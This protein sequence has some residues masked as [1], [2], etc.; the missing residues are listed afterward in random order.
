MSATDAA[1]GAAVEALTDSTAS[2][3]VLTYCLSLFS[4]AAIGE[5][6]SEAANIN[7]AMH[8]MIVNIVS[9]AIVGL[10]VGAFI[11]LLTFDVLPV[12]PI[13]D[14]LMGVEPK[15]PSTAL[16]K[17]KYES[18]SFIRNLG[19]VNVFFWTTMWGIYII[20]FLRKV[21]IPVK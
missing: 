13:Y 9:P 8:M 10:V 11:D 7:I 1:L 21:M 3:G 12:E 16:V 15:E 6:L 17:A 4:G 20:S 2:G 14:W 5:L 18:E 19:S